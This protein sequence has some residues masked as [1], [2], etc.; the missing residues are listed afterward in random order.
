MS[1]AYVNPDHVHVLIDLPVQ[2]SIAETVQILKGASSHYIN[3]SDLIPGKF[4]WGRG[5]GAFSVSHSDHGRVARY[6]ARQE[7]HHRQKAFIDEYQG[8]IERYGLRW[9]D[10]A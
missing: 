1:I 8:F 2:R 7:A 10:D 3:H 6:I 5:Y 9:Y 4:A